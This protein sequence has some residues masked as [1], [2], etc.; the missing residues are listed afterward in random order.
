M[1]ESISQQNYLT[2]KNYNQ[3]KKELATAALHFLLSWGDAILHI[4]K[5]LQDRTIFS[6]R[7]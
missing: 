2:I 1:V 7:F 6:L 3:A 4:T 5:V